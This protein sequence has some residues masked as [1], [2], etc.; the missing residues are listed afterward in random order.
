MVTVV[1]DDEVS[2]VVEGHKHAVRVRSVSIFSAQLS[3][4]TDPITSDAISDLGSSAVVIVMIVIG[5]VVAGCCLAIL[6][7]YKKP[8]EVIR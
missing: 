5:I 4:W 2:D 6:L 3:P 1:T 7:W 8:C